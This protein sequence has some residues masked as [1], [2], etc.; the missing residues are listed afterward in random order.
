MSVY[1]YPINTIDGTSLDW[2]RFKNQVL[3]IV[4]T[5]SKCG[6]SR[7]FA[8]LQQLYVD[9]RE[10]GFTVLGFP[11]NQFNSKE[12][13]DH[14]EINAY[15]EQ[16][17]GVTFPLSEKIEVRGSSAHPLFQYL[18]ETAPFQGFDLGTQG[19]EWMNHFLQEKYPDILEGCGIKWNFTKFL[20]DR[21]GQVFRRYEPTIEPAEIEADLQ[22]L[23]AQ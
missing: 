15:C 20:I 1:D 4:N 10:Q 22:R 19:G 3:L 12:P 8:G 16:N 17:F 11:C 9:Y 2:S 23:L 6:Y 13:G 14:N 7:Q 5:A 18:T 21:S